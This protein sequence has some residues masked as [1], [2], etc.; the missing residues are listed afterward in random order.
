MGR[1][2]QRLQILGPDAQHDGL[3]VVLLQDR[4]HS[5]RWRHVEL[6][7]A[8]KG[9]AVLPA[10][11]PFEKVHRRVPDESSD[12]AVRRVVVHGRR[13]V[14]LLDRS[15]VHHRDAVAH[16]HCLYLVVRDVDGGRSDLGQKLFQL[17]AHLQP[18]QRVEIAQRLVHQQHLRLHRDGARHRHALPLTAAHLRRV[19]VEHRL[20]VQQLRRPPHPV[21]YLRLLLLL[22]PQAKGDIVVDVHMRE[23]GV[24]L[25]DHGD[26]P[27]PRGQ[28]GDVP[29]ADADPAFVR[30]A[31]P[32]DGAEQRRLAAAA[33][34]QQHHE[35]M[36]GDDERD[37]VHRHEVAEPLDDIFYSYLRHDSAPS[38]ILFTCWTAP[39]C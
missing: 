34:T 2:V 24:A 26:A 22:H 8:D 23:D 29:P 3:A 14:H 32:G 30:H 10:D 9:I 19:A 1:F 38:V 13:G 15:A 18:E 17:G 11:L 36:L 33:G 20:D 16:A 6:S 37:V 39:T 27:F 12:K 25:K 21:F 28:V 5:G 31:E 35:L 7:Q 4:L